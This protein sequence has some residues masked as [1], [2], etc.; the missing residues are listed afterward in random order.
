MH[1]AGKKCPEMQ[2]PDAVNASGLLLI[3]NVSLGAWSTY[4]SY[5]A[6]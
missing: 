6:R 4:R 1:R 3:L 5:K 2:K